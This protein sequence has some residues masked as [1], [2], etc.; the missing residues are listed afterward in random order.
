M[1]WP[2]PSV[3]H[4]IFEP[5]HSHTNS[6][7]AV[8]GPQYTRYMQPHDGIE[9]C[10]QCRNPAPSDYTLVEVG[11]LYVSVSV[12]DVDLTPTRIPMVRVAFWCHGQRAS[13]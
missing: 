10:F 7:R 4:Q 1:S 5:K 13:R 8:S 6:F 2:S 12:F 3:T 11:Y 9:K